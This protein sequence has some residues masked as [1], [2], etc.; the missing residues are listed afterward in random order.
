[1]LRN[2][3]LIGLDNGYAILAAVVS[4]SDYTVCNKGGLLCHSHDCGQSW[5]LCPHALYFVGATAPSAPPP[6][7]TA[8]DMVTYKLQKHGCLVNAKSPEHGLQI[9]I[10]YTLVGPWVIMTFLFL[11]C[12]VGQVVIVTF[13]SW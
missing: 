4:I 10:H 12:T 3:R 2:S 6:S 5:G 7:S 13:G 8:Y 1:M 11:D 9:F